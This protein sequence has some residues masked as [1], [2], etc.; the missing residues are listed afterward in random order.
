M[1]PG[2]LPRIG[3]EDVARWR[4]P[5][6]LDFDKAIWGAPAFRP[7]DEFAK[8]FHA[9]GIFSEE[10][11][12]PPHEQARLAV[13]KAAI[14]AAKAVTMAPEAT[15][16]LNQIRARRRRA[17][18]AQRR[19]LAIELE[20]LKDEIRSGIRADFSTEELEAEAEAVAGRIADLERRLK[21][22]SAIS[23]RN[24]NTALA[25]LFQSLR[26]DWKMLTGRNPAKTRSETGACEFPEFVNAVLIALGLQSGDSVPAIRRAYAEIASRRGWPGMNTV[27]EGPKLAG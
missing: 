27:L 23:S 6:L 10:Y 8:K 25:W 2:T 13:T 17:L 15:D 12:M 18:N 20:T 11:K 7:I 26:I 9:A 19:Q 4:A 24:A 16:Q 3:S 14:Q 5:G 22:A 1:K 21:R